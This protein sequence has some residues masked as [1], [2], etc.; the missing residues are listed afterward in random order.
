MFDIGF[1]EIIIILIIV[2][3]VVGPDQLPA[4]AR[5]SGRAIS[6]IKRLINNLQREL[7]QELSLQDQASFKQQL[8]ELDDLMRDAPDKAQK[9]SATDQ[10]D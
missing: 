2:L 1:W 3:L 9:F 5:Q 6:E 8:D 10:R 4:F 7:K